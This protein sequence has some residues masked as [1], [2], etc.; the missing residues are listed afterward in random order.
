MVGLDAEEE[1][2]LLH[3]SIKPVA[4]SLSYLLLVRLLRNHSVMIRQTLLITCWDTSRY[5]FGEQVKYSEP[6]LAVGNKTESPD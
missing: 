2:S 6:N 3:V 4:L 5:R 1:Y